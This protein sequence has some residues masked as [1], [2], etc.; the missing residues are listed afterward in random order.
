ML[1]NGSLAGRRKGES[2][3][4]K[5]KRALEKCLRNRK[6]MRRRFKVVEMKEGIGCTIVF[7][8]V[9]FQVYKSYFLTISH[10]HSSSSHK[11]T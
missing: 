6:V 10:V 8:Q 9:C 4:L 1:R 2:T 11:H 5:E 3:H 7:V